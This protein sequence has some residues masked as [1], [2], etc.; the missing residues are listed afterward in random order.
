M[1]DCG[2]SS[3]P[4][5]SREEFGNLD[6]FF[7]ERTGLALAA[8][9]LAVIEQRLQERLVAL[10]LSSFADYCRFLRFG[11]GCE[12]ELHH[13]LELITSGETYFFRHEQQLDLLA[14]VILPAL[15]AR[16]AR[17]RRLSI[18]SAGCSTGEEVYTLAMLAQETGLF[19]GWNLCVMGGDLCRGRIAVARAGV[20]QQ[21][22]FRTTSA[23]RR[24]TF[25]RKAGDGEQVEAEIRK[26]CR[27]R[28]M[29][30]LD[31][32]AL[33]WIGRVDLALCRNVLLYLEPSARQKVV[34]NLHSRLMPGGYLLL[35]HAEALHTVNPDLPWN[36]LPHDLAFQRPPLSRRGGSP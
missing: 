30:L 28:P 15:A 33:A 31:E 11:E 8:S 7:R 10:R 22:A 13:A 25:F 9:S 24:A 12:E 1:S 29:N 34:A 36:A 21:S 16:N 20:Y 4:R 17:S 23:Q 32:A 26:L 18:W 35:G 6:D 2:G 19:R 3:Q 5:L 27:F 14:T